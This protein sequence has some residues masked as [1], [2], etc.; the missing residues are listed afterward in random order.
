MGQRVDDVPQVPVGRKVGAKLL[1]RL[2]RVLVPLLIRDDGQLGRWAEL[3][4]AG[5]LLAARGAEVDAHVCSMNSHCLTIHSGD[6]LK[7]PFM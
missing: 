5:V 7:S 4:G 2:V 6:F 3:L 1:P